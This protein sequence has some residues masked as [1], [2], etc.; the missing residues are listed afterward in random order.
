MPQHHRA[1][2]RTNEQMDG[3]EMNSRKQEINMTFLPRDISAWFDM[4]SLP[5][6]PKAHIFFGMCSSVWPMNNC[7]NV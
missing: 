1:S 4:N 3:C 5:L 2:E 6:V 7:I